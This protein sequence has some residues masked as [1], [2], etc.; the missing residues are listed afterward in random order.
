MLFLNV[1]AEHRHINHVPKT[2]SFEVINVMHFQNLLGIETLWS[3]A[4]QSSDT[5]VANE[6]R[7]F[8]VDVHLK[9]VIEQKHK[10]V[11][12]ENFLKKTEEISLQ[13]DNLEPAK[14]QRQIEMRLNWVTLI[15]EY[16][17]RF[18]Y[19]HIPLEDIKKYDEKS[20]LKV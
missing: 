18:D 15:R 4:I 8:L 12:V 10:R 20:N 11:F 3:I 13:L 16:V 2:G 19:M 14:R 17:K 6:A 1:N 9:S 5:I 7:N